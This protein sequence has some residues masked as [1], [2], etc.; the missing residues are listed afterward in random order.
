M[1]ITRRAALAAMGHAVTPLPHVGGGMAAIRF[2]PDG[3]L[4][5]A[6]CWRADGTAMGMGGGLA[7]PGARFWPDAPRR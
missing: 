2:H 4:E 3:L 5:G 1:S 7:R 6:A